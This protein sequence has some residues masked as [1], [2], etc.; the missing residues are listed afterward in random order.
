MLLRVPKGAGGAK[1]NSSAVTAAITGT[2]VMVETHA[3]T[4]KNR[5]SYY[6]F[7]V[8]EGTARLYLPGRLGESTLVKAGQMIIMRADSKLIPEPVDVDIGK[9]TQSSLL[10]TGFSAP[11]GSEALIAFEKTKQNEQ[12]NSGQLYATNFDANHVDSGGGF[13]FS[14]LQL[15]GNPTISTV[16]GE[17]NLGLISIGNITSAAP[18]GTLTFAG[19]RSLLLATQNGSITLGPEISF[20]SLQDITFYARGAGSALTFGSAISNVQHLEVDAEGSIQLNGAV[21]VQDI[22]SFAGVD[23]LAGSG[24]ITAT[25]SIDIH[26]DNDVNFN[27]NQFPEGTNTGQFVTID[28]GHNVN[29]DPTGDQTV[30]TNANI[31][32][33][34]AGNAIN[35]TGTS[36]T[37]LNL[38]SS[39]NTFGFI[40]AFSAGSDFTL[41]SGLTINLDNSGSGNLTAGANII[42][43]ATGNIIVNNNGSLDLNVLNNDGVKIGSG[44]DIALTAGKN[45]TANSINLFV[46]NRNG[47]NIGSGG[48]VSLFSGGALT[49]TGD[50][51]LGVSTRNDGNG[52][53][54]ISSSSE[55][56]FTAIGISFGGFFPA[57]VRHDG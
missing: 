55:V 24:S 40:V 44:G 28:A 50:V 19:I 7:I 57:F 23:F 45:L 43:G 48:N 46:N 8:L 29:I 27:L 37:T 11:I 6:K 31:I 12:K 30:F 13:K 22:G 49:A 41:A 51:T 16:N 4:K 47:G 20:S 9:I 10:V 21:T 18:G 34:H 2:T 14:A 56:I 52:G 5:N 35:I 1:I 25:T 54:I 32:T 39:T 3:L 53:G 17:I 26:A 36:P 15:T 38:T 33:V 42:L